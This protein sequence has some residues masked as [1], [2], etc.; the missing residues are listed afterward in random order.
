M[1]SWQCFNRSRVSNVSRVSNT[2]RGK[3]YL[4]L[5][6]VLRYP[7]IWSG[8][9]SIRQWIVES[10][11]CYQTDD[12]HSNIWASSQR[13]SRSQTC[14]CQSHSSRTRLSSVW[15]NLW[16]GLRSPQSSKTGKRTSSSQY[17][18]IVEISWLQ[19]RGERWAVRLYELWYWAASTKKK[20][21]KMKDMAKK[22][23]KILNK[24]IF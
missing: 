22:R 16:L 19:G 7:W 21:E 2:S 5:I 20:N 10:D 14:C 1:A 13:T 18:V 6:E 12:S 23:T 9:S 15:Q 3:K 24:E 17:N 4:V 11:L 8:T